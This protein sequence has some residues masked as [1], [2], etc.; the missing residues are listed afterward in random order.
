MVDINTLSFIATE[1]STTASLA[2]FKEILS[3]PIHSISSVSSS[4]SSSPK[5]VNSSFEI[6][7]LNAVAFGY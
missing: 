1:S 2:V 6:S 3:T 5:W 7:W 4:V